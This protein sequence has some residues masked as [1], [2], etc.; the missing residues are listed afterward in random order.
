MPAVLFGR[1]RLDRDDDNTIYSGEISKPVDVKLMV[2][3]ARTR[4]Q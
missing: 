3:T 1:V 4:S 2:H